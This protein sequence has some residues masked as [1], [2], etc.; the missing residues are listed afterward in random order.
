MPEFQIVKNK[1]VFRSIRCEMR[2]AREIIQKLSWENNGPSY[3]LYRIRADGTVYYIGTWL[4]GKFQ[5]KIIK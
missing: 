3:H 1:K 4:S 5:G 2:E